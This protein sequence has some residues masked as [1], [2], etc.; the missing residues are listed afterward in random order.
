MKEK[1]NKVLKEIKDD[2]TF[3]KIYNEWF[4]LDY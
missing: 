4:S 3:E 1:I 2:G